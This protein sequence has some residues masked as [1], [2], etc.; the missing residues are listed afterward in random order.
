MLPASLNDLFIVHSLWFDCRFTP[1]RLALLSLLTVAGDTEEASVQPYS[2][3]HITQIPVQALS[4]RRQP[5]SRSPKKQPIQLAMPLPLPSLMKS[6]ASARLESRPSPPASPL[7]QKPTSTSSLESP[8]APLAQALGSPPSPAP[9]P[10]PPSRPKRPSTPLF[11]AHPTSSHT[12]LRTSHASSLQ[13]SSG[14]GQS[15]V[16]NPSHL[17]TSASGTSHQST[18]SSQSGSGN[19]SERRRSTHHGSNSPPPKIFI[20]KA[21]RSDIRAMASVCSE[22]FWNDDLFGELIHPARAKFPSDFEQYFRR[23][24]RESWWNREKEVWVAVVVKKR[25]GR[26]KDKETEV[27]RTEEREVVIGVAEW[28]R[29]GCGV[30]ARGRQKKRTTFA[31]AEEKHPETEEPKGSCENN[32]AGNTNYDIYMKIREDPVW[33]DTRLLLRPLSRVFNATSKLLS[34][35]RAANPKMLDV[36]DRAHVYYGRFWEESWQDEQRR[37][38]AGRALVA[39]GIERARREG[40]ISASVVSAPGKERFYRRC[41]FGVSVGWIT[42]GDGNPLRGHL[43]G[44]EVLFWD[45]DGDGDGG[46]KGIGA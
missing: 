23:R 33:Y 34:P 42:E 9:T 3:S 40:N 5:D 11:C 41:G 46:E 16:A 14:H 4:E 8:T 27:A 18:K 39:W 28:Q 32:S 31:K 2:A 29:I 43:R 36:L 7:P 44:G 30:W 1:I 37:Y 21:R 24:E 45:G 22:A 13:T 25:K 19:S 12:S 20:R 15:S 26:G 10:A 38:G 35:N 17:A 6:S